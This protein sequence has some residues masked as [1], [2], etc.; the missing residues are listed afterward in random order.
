M[1]K[2]FLGDIQ[3]GQLFL[4][5]TESK[6]AIKVFRLRQGDIISIIDGTGSEYI[7]KITNPNPKKCHFTILRQNRINRPSYR[8]HLAIAPTKNLDRMEWM[9]EKC[10]EIG[11]DELSFFYSSNSERKVMKLE[12]L[13]KKTVSAIKQSNN[14]FLP[15]LN[16][17]V[18]FE[19]LLNNLPDDCQRLIGHLKR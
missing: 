8:I 1:Q 4:T 7:C 2:F 17:I 5:E 19:S 14:F 9:V 13:I 10:T 15:N 6:H 3:N 18:S 16:Q 12:R 11:I